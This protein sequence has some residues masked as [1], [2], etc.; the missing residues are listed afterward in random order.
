MGLV[1]LPTLT[2]NIHPS[3]FFLILG[4]QYQ[5]LNRAW[6]VTK[7]HVWNTMLWECGGC[8]V[9]FV[10]WKKGAYRSAREY[11]WGEKNYSWHCSIYSVI[12][13]YITIEPENDDPPKV[14]FLWDPC[15]TSRMEPVFVLMFWGLWTIAGLGNNQNGGQSGGSRYVRNK[16]H[17]IQQR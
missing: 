4:L 11:C 13:V 2:I 1:F 8:L 10:V 16:E 17:L 9:F 5:V 7:K 12:N 14:I 3:H 15:W 6:E